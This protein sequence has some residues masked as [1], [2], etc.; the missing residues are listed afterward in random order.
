MARGP[1]EDERLVVRA[2]PERIH[3]ERIFVRDLADY[4]CVQQKL[5]RA[6]AR[7]RNLLH[8][9]SGGSAR[10]GYH[11]VTAPVATRI[12]AY[13]RALQG[14]EYL[15]GNEIHEKRERDRCAR[16]RRRGKPG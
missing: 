8:K 6:W 3:G 4:L 13:F 2:L 11:W 15:A 14:A 7:P 9:A 16:R 12:I 1:A 10:A 5:I